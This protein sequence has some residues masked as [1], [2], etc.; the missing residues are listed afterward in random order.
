[1]AKTDKEML[2]K[3]KQRIKRQNN[4]I[5][6]D[7]DR[8]SATLPKGTIDRIK[9]LGLTI[10]GV[11]NDSVL[12]FLECMEEEHGE[13]PKEPIKSVQNVETANKNQ[14]AGEST[15]AQE[16]SENKEMKGDKAE[17]EKPTSQYGDCPFL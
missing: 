14:N 10:N 7:Y 17:T 9:A 5:K 8:V 15:V 3:Y 2:E 1:M 11:I 13:P 4:K 16:K 12:S 6:E